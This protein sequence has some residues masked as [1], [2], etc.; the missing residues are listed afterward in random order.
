MVNAACGYDCGPFPVDDLVIGGENRGPNH[1]PTQ[2]T[3]ENRPASGP[4]SESVDGLWRTWGRV[5]R[6]QSRSNSLIEVLERVRSS[7]V[8]T[9]T[10][11]LIEGR[12]SP[13]G[14]GIEPGMITE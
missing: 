5:P 12:P 8:L 10:A 11:Q 2:R 3:Y 13:N 4:V 1:S 7:T 6:D 14:L 9:I